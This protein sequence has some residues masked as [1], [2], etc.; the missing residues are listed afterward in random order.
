MKQHVFVGFGFGP[1]QSGLFAAEA[2]NSGNFN[3]IV[4]S[5]IDQKLVDAV[6]AN[7]G[8]YYVNVAQADCIEVR[9]IQ[10]IEILNPTVPEDNDQLRQ[11]LREAT[12]IATSLPA[13]KIYTAGGPNS[14]AS[15][16]ADGLQ[17]S[18]VKGT[19]IYTG[20]NNNHAAEILEEEVVGKMS[21]PPAGA[22]DFLNTVIGKMSRVVTDPAEIHAM[23]LKPMAPGIERAFLVEA[24]N[25]ILV[26]RTILDIKP[27]IEVFIEKDDLL[28]F[29]EAKLYG[30]NAIHAL[31]GYLGN[32]KGCAKMTDLQQNPDLMRIGRDAF[33]NESGKALINKYAQLNDE[34]FTTAGYQEYA[35]DLLQRMT[36]PFL[37]DTTERAARDP[38]RKLGYDDR[39][40]GT[41]V[42]CLEN[43]VEPTNMAIGAAA[44][45]VALL[46]QADQ[47]DIPKDL[48]CDNWQNLNASQ[49]D[50]ICRWLWSGNIGPYAEKLIQL[51]QEAH[52][53]L[54]KLV[55]S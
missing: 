46:Q 14:V 31:L 38:L 16:I 43:N 23:N 36:N 47:C 52:P 45:L 20:E 34:L 19:I 9:E 44:G 25:K 49:I 35:D 2:F 1:I 12:E 50:A 40:F 17:K 53:R 7:N 24:F 39:I 41:M 51:T 5:E 21:Q 10:G 32:A 26:T 30:H 42:V 54:V 37:E 18:K 13:V 11:V 48:R 55:N 28:P 6:R 3:R 8:T 4:V 27:G 29:E 33:I 22:A 15:L